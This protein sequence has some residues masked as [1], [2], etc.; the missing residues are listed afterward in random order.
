MFNNNHG[1][2]FDNNVPDRFNNTNNVF[3]Y[4]D[5]YT[6]VEERNLIK[7]ILMETLLKVKNVIQ[8]ET[9]IQKL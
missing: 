3:Y 2:G 1:P 6:E 5:V 9:S 8:I 4:R 7:V